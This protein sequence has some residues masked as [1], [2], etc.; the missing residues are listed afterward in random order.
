MTT[1]KAPLGNGV[2]GVD[3]AHGPTHTP[4]PWAVEG[5]DAF[6]DFAIIPANDPD[7]VAVVVAV[8]VADVRNPNPR[9]VHA[10]AR[11]AAAAPELLAALVDL[12]DRDLE[13][14]GNEIRIECDSHGHAMELARRGRAAISKA[15]TES[16]DR[17]EGS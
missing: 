3:A 13:Y 15:Q 8:V 9:V 12:V 6:G 1:H 14:N 11:L 10:N 5:P 4:G 16:A 17:G 7:A 2:D